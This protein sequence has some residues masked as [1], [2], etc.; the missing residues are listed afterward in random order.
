MHGLLENET[1]GIFNAV[2]GKTSSFL[3]ITQIINGLFPAGIK[4]E[5]EAR[6]M[7]VPHK[8]YRAFDDSKLRQIIPGF[9]STP[10]DK[11]LQ[12]YYLKIKES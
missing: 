8:G 10:L 11:A 3:E 9:K 12:S 7:P 5:F 2:S 6:K 4:V 1:G